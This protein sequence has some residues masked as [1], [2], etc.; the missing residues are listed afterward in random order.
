MKAAQGSMG[1]VF[2]LRLEDGDRLP[3]CIEQFAGENAI[4]GGLVALVGGIGSGTLVVGP[5]DSDAEII[6]PM[7]KIFN[8]A[9]EA[10][11]LGTLFADSAG[12]PKLHM[13]TTLGR[14][15]DT[16]TGCIRQGIDVWKIAEVVILEIVDSG[17]VRK[18]DPAFN[19]ELLSPE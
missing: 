8:A 6:T 19:L 1:R 17:M 12:K 10:A 2:V 13:H 9:H 15:D 14:G 3:D 7:T 18:L 5:E 16:L 4:R 11:A